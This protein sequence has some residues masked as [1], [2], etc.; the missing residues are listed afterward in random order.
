[1]LPALTGWN[2]TRDGLHTTALTLGRIRKSFIKPQPNA[3]HLTLRVTRAGL[4]TGPLLTT[5][6]THSIDADFTTQQIS[7]GFADDPFPM[8]QTGLNA[9]LE[10]AA[11]VS[12]N[13]L[14]EGDPVPEIEIAAPYATEYANVQY[15]VFTALA[16]FR[17]GISG[18]MTPLIVWPH[19][20]DLSFLYFT[21]DGNDEHNDPHMNFG[22]APYSDTIDRPYLYMYGWPLPDGITTQPLPA[23]AQWVTDG[24]TGV[25]VD[26]DTL[27]AETDP[28][29]VIEQVCDGLFT[30]FAGQ[31][32]RE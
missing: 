31:M 15:T 18:R 26:Y 28:Q 9:L 6:G 3:L 8:T 30:L 16:R 1:M 25:M 20:F 17:A 13:G 27:V 21:G 19:H 14:R 23:P 7:A 2:P 11:A 29:A 10:A 4:T 24:W 12:E 32:G 5:S 22:F